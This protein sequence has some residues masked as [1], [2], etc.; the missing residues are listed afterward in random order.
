MI[1]TVTG[2]STACF[3]PKLTEDSLAWAGEL[4]FQTVEL[5]FNASCE[6][7]GPTLQDLDAIRR[8]YGM[9][10]V[11]VHPFTSVAEG[12]LFFSDYERRVDDGLDLYRR[13]FEAAAQ[14]GAHLL[15]L[16]GGKAVKHLPPEFYAERLARL[17]EAGHE[18]GVTV[19]HENVVH[20]ACESVDYAKKLASLLGDSFR[21]VLD[22]KQCVRAGQDP[23]AFIRELGAHIDHVHVS[24]HGARGDC[25]PPGEGDFDFTRL[26][27][28]LS[29]AGYRGAS[30]IELYSNGFT[31][32]CQ[33][34][35]ARRYLEKCDQNL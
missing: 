17:I 20:F 30:I 7:G 33:L 2:I 8:S 3:Y 31:D 12:S 13:Y 14:L 25:L 11:S 26:F 9:D 1:A 22:I 16:H 4:G 10:I 5:F 18:F 6:L 32:V 21:M 23:F 34:T 27:R 19:A 35:A 15:V 29:G 28:E 24:D